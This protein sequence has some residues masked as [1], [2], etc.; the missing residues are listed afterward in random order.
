M[1][2]LSVSPQSI[3]VSDQEV[4]T[5]LQNENNKNRN[6]WLQNNIKDHLRNSK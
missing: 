4:L 6:E 5:P 1:V 3:N 2:E